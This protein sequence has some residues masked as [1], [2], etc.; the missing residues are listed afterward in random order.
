VTGSMADR[1][2]ISRAWASCAF[3]LPGDEDPELVIL[4]RI[5]AAIPLVDEDALHGVADEPFHIG[6]T[7]HSVWPS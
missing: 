5:V 2:R 7:V 4:W 3:S 6:I 1:L